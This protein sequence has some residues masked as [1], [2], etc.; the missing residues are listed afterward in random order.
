MAD[1]VSVTVI[2]TG[3]NSLPKPHVQAQAIASEQIAQQQ[4]SAAQQ[5]VHEQP[6]SAATQLK[7]QK[8]HTAAVEAAPARHRAA[9]LEKEAFEAEFLKEFKH[10]LTTKEQPKTDAHELSV[11]PLDLD[12]PAYLRRK[13]ADQIQE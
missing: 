7:E 10:E 3:F 13:S 8:P 1:E 5:I 6:V 12:V 11:N 9:E 4:Q 2:A